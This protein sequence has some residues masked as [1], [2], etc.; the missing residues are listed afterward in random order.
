MRTGTRRPNGEMNSERPAEA[1]ATAL[2]RVAALRDAA[3]LA[4]DGDVRALLT[5][6]LEELAAAFEELSVGQEELRRRTV[7]MEDQVRARIAELA[8]AEADL[9]AADRRKD[10]FIATVAHEL[11]SPLAAI[12]T[13][14]ELVRTRKDL[15]EEAVR[16]LGVIDRQARRIGGL[17]SDLLDVSRIAQGKLSVHPEQL[18]LTEA[19]RGAVDAIRPAA[20]GL[21]VALD[22]AGGAVRVSADPARLDQVLTNLLTNAVKYTDAGGTVAVRVERDGDW[23]VVRVRDSG[24]G[25]AP[26][27]LPRVFDLF[28]QAAEDRSQ[29]GLGIGLHLVKRLVELHGGS[30]AA[31]SDGPSR[32]SEFVVRLPAVTGA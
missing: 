8:G 21:A 13:A 7:E 3:G 10:E 22:A 25:I 19:C 17:V 31:H 2:K 6:G 23:A 16:P 15:P 28:V 24:V 30:V 9:R 27:V 26:G 1:A 18:D 20:A 5:E 32:G 12:R 11:R 29:G 14:A 4:A